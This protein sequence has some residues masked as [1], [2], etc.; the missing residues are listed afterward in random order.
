MFCRFSTVVGFR[1]SVDTARDVHGHAC[2]FYTD[3][4]NYGMLCITTHNNNC[5]TC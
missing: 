1:G 4:G 5:R 2:R 3:E